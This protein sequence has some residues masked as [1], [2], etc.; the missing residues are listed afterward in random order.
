[1]ESEKHDLEKSAKEI[2]YKLE[3]EVKLWESK[4]ADF[5]MELQVRSSYCSCN[6]FDTSLLL[7]GNK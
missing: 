6:H 1:M 4:A 2:E 5:E 3:K 7:T